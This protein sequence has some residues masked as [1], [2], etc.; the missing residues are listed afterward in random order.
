MMDAFNDNQSGKPRP[1]VV[2]PLYAVTALVFIVAVGVIGWS[3]LAPHPQPSSSR[4]VPPQP[5]ASPH[6]APPVMPRPAIVGAVDGATRACEA[7]KSDDATPS[8]SHRDAAA[9]LAMCDALTGQRTTVKAGNVAVS[10]DLPSVVVGF[11]LALFLWGVL[12]GLGSMYRSAF[13]RAPAP[14][15]WASVEPFEPEWRRGG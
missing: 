13:R 1:I 9:A 7:W 10:L 4:P 12:V 5:L 15:R 14:Q 6:L 3:M 8:L 2:R 11:V